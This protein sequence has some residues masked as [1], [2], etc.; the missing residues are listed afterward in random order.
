M[1]FKVLK[2]RPE[3]VIR[4]AEEDDMICGFYIAPFRKRWLLKV[5]ALTNCVI[6]CKRNE[7]SIPVINRIVVF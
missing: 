4:N 7:V 2:N 3:G 5:P 1:R 6:L